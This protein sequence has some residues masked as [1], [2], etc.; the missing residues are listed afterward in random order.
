MV[1]ENITRDA[2]NKFPARSY[3]AMIQ[4]REQN[5][6]KLTA[7]A[8]I[9]QRTESYDLRDHFDDK[10]VESNVIDLFSYAVKLSALISRLQQHHKSI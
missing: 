2:S 9:S 6:Q 5:R 7:I 8:T 1:I 3:S 4:M 10:N